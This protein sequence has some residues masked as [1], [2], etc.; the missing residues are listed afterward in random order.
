MVFSPLSR[1]ESAVFFSFPG[2]LPLIVP[3]SWLRMWQPKLAFVSRSPTFWHFAS[4]YAIM[5]VL[6]GLVRVA[7]ILAWSLASQCALGVSILK[8]FAWF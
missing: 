8:P 5:G 2:T 6:S 4:K 3:G 1:A 7:G